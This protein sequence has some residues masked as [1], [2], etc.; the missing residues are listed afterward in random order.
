MR[1]YNDI[2]TIVA[3]EC[4][5][6]LLVYHEPHTGLMRRCDIIVYMGYI[7]IALNDGE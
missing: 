3:G 1:R 6:Q 7:G 4:S 5:L 2:S